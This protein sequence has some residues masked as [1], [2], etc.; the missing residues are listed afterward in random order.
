MNK[1]FKDILTSLLAYAI[2]ALVI[3]LV[4]N[5]FSFMPHINYWVSYGLILILMWIKKG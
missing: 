4:W 3:M 1:K 5:Y 2:K